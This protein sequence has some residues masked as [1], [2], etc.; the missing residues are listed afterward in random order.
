M[1]L[2]FLFSALRRESRGGRSRLIFFSLCIGLGVA[3][4]VAVAG[5][6]QS[7]ER[8]IRLQARQL[9]AADL[10]VSSYRPLPPSVARV[11]ASVPGAEMAEVQELVTVAALPGTAE[12]PGRSALVELK[13]VGA[14]YP[15]FGE[16]R[17][18]PAQPLAS[19][20]SSETAVIGPELA[21]RLGL[22]TGSQLLIGNAPFR[23]SG[24]V[25]SEPDRI[26]GAF[27]LGPRVF[28]SAEGAVR[29]G[30][31][32]F[33]SRV[34]HKALI[35]LP[36]T[37]QKKDVEALAAR[38]RASLETPASFRIES[39]SEAQPAL[40][41]GLSRVDR[42][43]GL[44]ALLSLLVGGAGVAQTVRAW[45]ATRLDSLAIMKCL[46]M[47]PREVLGLYLVQI[48]G[49]ALAASL[50]GA[51]LG[52]M[53]LFLVPRFVGPI[54]PD[55]WLQP[56][57]M[58]AWIR[59]ITLGLGVGAIFSLPPLVAAVRVPP[60]RVLRRD[61]EP[62]PPTRL[63]SALSAG[64]VI[65]GV[66]AVAVAQSRSFR[67]GGLFT[68]GLLVATGILAG[69]ATGL[70]KS[71]AIIPRAR[72]PFWLR[73]GLSAL[74]RP[75][76]GTVPSLVALGLG[77]L[78]VLAMALVERHLTGEL[79]SSLPK[80]APTVFLIDIQPDQWDGVQRVLSLEGAS[81]L[82]SV[83]MVMA[84]LARINGRKVDEIARERAASSPE[85]RQWA[86]TREQRL[87]YMEVLPSDNKIVSGKLWSLKGIPELSVEE[88]FAR[89]TLGIDVGA[90]LEFDIQ[91]VPL[92]L[93]VT[94][95]R[96][97]DWRTFG[98]NFF[99][100]AEPGILENAPQTRLA[101]ARLAE[102]KEDRVQDLLAREYPNV[103][104]IRTREVLVRIAGI[105]DKLGVAVQFLGVFSVVAGLV[106]LAGA[107]SAGSV[108]KSRETA[109]LK[110]MGVSRP[111]V[112][113]IFAVEYFLGG[114]VA[115]G[116]GTVGGALLSW[117]VVTHGFQIGWQPGIVILATAPLG[118]AL[119]AC[120]AG[121]SASLRALTVRP[122]EALRSE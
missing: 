115:G 87:T 42:Y 16:I 76:E 77:I 53:V 44:V 37:A 20:L 122:L 109:I 84:R 117:F 46:G 99:W 114:L 86:L 13:A 120:A 98:I 52:S 35:K 73:H 12:Q 41:Q 72:L 55:G 100:V 106:L 112:V 24:I 29:T 43:L 116:V 91:G 59:G 28:L 81:R 51:A 111:G 11:I 121:L 68:A 22:K 103:T 50:A 4:V 45:L 14:G 60:S 104:M 48:L 23:V 93:T 107:I 70:V 17:L 80:D 119:L 88:R 113:G 34:L 108:R 82:D 61:V 33:G 36:Q 66:L 32:Q 64:V 83:P 85:N 94:S 69:M 27:S 49:L 79:R 38:I 10:A 7:V 110:V 89:E 54:L 8:G 2:G 74:S 30:V 6:T 57:S 18:E 19:L 3:A 31:I 67:D 105:F 102:G 96:K 65:L 95:L 56:F 58:V 26:S 15:F 39:F 101:A 47:R 62:L 25:Y 5:L 1:T 118:T 71:S 9:L 63:V 92:E 78:V 21:A 40:R 97:V 75:G 90:K